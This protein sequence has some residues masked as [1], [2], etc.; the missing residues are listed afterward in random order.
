MNDFG[1]FGIVHEPKA[2]SGQKIGI[3]SLLNQNIVVEGYRVG[4]SIIKGKSERLD[5]QIRFNGEQRVTWASSKNLV[6]MI[7]K[8]PKDKFPFTA[9]IVAIEG[10]G[11]KFVPA[12]KVK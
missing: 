2:F 1:D 8:I 10:G 3:Q 12:E 9:R 11:F 4:P 5:L 7:E 6:A